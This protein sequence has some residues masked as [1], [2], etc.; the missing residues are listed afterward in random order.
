M[1]L[2]LQVV[3]L[4]KA[5]VE[6]TWEDASSLPRSLVSSYEAGVVLQIQRDT[7]IT[8]AHA[9][10]TL[11]TIEVS[12]GPEPNSKRPRTDPSDTLSD[13]SG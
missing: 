9:V 7:S 8:G 4:G 3:W 1:P 11:T 6:S 13:T 2:S 12:D 5:E 10:H